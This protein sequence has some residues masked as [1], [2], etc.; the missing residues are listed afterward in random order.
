MTAE[1]AEAERLRAR[2][3]E[4]GNAGSLSASAELI[5]F[6]S[7]PAPRVRR[8]AASAIQKIVNAHTY[9]DSAARTFATHLYMKAL[10]ETADQVREYMLKALSACAS[11]MT[12]TMVRHLRDLAR[13]PSLKPYV[14][15]AANEAVYAG[16]SSIRHRAAANETRCTRCHRLISPEEAKNGLNKYGKAYCYHCFDERLLEDVNFEKNVEEAK[17]LR[18]TNEVAV[19]SQGE[20]RIGNYLAENGIRYVYD[21]RFRI[22]ASAIL[23][24]DFYLPEFDLYIEYWGMDTDDYLERR[25]EKQFLYQRAGKKLISLTPDDLPQIEAILEE[26][27][28]RYMVT[29]IG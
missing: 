27:L 29:S 4:L 17:K 23:R 26:K 24:P 11:A 6:L 16:E 21:E 19:Q 14:R 12:A 5:R 13:D 9:N 15:N 18:T 25:R 8:A 1:S 20:R 2:A 28:A 22:A 10:D 7:H 3:V